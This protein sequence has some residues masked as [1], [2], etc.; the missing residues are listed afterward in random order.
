MERNLSSPQK[1]FLSSCSLGTAGQAEVQAGHLRH[2]RFHGPCRSPLFEPSFRAVVYRVARGDFHL[3][4]LE[5]AAAG[6]ELAAVDT[7][8]ARVHGGAT[9][10]SLLQCVNLRRDGPWPT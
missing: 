1:F 9:L 5:V 3:L 7:T 10:W 4:L 2:D 6:R 8:R